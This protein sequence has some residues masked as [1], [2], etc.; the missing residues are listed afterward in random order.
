MYL[1]R[2]QTSANRWTLKTRCYAANHLSIFIYWL[3][4]FGTLCQRGSGSSRPEVKSAPEST[5]PWVN[6]VQCNCILYSWVSDSII[7]QRSRQT[8][9]Y[10]I[11]VSIFLF[12]I[13]HVGCVWSKEKPH[14][15]SCFEYPKH[16]F[17][18]PIKKYVGRFCLITNSLIN[19][20]WFLSTVRLHH[21][22]RGQETWYLY[23]I[24][25][26]LSNLQCS[27]KLSI[28]YKVRRLYCCLYCLPSC[29]CW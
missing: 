12:I 27:A 23:V 14:W 1:Y 5:P 25:L 4:P 21:I 26:V 18:L 16:M 19:G 13:F 8:Q 9:Y 28:W 6:L 3:A 29:L 22:S 11:N 15:S 17:W 10:S 2:T 7:D 20:Y 24:C